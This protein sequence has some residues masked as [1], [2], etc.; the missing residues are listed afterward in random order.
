MSDGL[1]LLQQWFLSQCNGDWEHGNGICI[2]TL[3]NPGWAVD[4]EIEG[5]SCELQKFEPIKI[6]RSEVDWLHAFRD[7]FIF[8]IRCGPQNL[9]EG[10]Q[11]FLKWANS[12]AKA[13]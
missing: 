7:H 13:P 6:N 9:E 2:R 8:K 11:I 12:A 5:T 3:D 10:V 1:I 4:V